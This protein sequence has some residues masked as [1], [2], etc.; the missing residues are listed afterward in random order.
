MPPAP[1]FRNTRGKAW[2]ADAVNCRFS[3]IQKNLNKRYPDYA[4]RHSWVTKALQS[5]VNPT[6]VAVLMGHHLP[7][8]LAK[9]YQHLFQDPTYL[10]SAVIRTTVLAQNIDSLRGHRLSVP[11]G[12]SFYGRPVLP[13]SWLRPQLLRPIN[14]CC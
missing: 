7:S 14:R 5:G 2:S 3:T 8:I 9:H 10:R 13:G 6:T 11:L 12:C 1:F 4:L